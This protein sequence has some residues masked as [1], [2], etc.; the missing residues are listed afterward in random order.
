MT[1]RIGDIEG[2]RAFSVLIVVL[3]HANG[4]L[5][6]WADNPYIN[7]FFSYFGGWVGVDLFFAISGFVIAKNLL[8]ALSSADSRQG[9][10]SVCIDF[11]VKRAY[12][13]L[14]SA[15]LWLVLSMLCVV[16]LNESGVWGSFRA[17][18]QSTLAALL[19]IM[20]VHAAE[21]FGQGKVANFIYWSL[22]LEEQFYLILPLAFFAL[23]SYFGYAV[24]ALFVFSLLN[25]ADSLFEMMFR[26]HAILGGVLLA[27]VYRSDLYRLF[28][29]K[30]L[31]ESR[32]AKY[33]VLLFLCLLLVS[34]GA[35]SLHVTQW[36]VSLIAIIA[37]LLVYI[38]SH[39][40]DY[41]LP[42]TPWLKGLII[43]CGAR[44]YSIYLTHIPSFFL[45]REIFLRLNQWGYDFQ[46][47]ERSLMVVSAIVL[48][49]GFS[50]LNYRL[51]ETPL[52]RR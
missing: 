30:F 28:E 45:T 42:K 25:P 5:I 23:R 40:K 3:H 50:E 21:T 10:F 2:L 4:N 39:N 38:A 29:P 26:V 52:R 17:N 20:N 46:E 48:V 35:K 18:W 27:L 31:G 51:V 19:N 7:T 6:T 32:L 41:I 37:I 33:S 16:F 24:L 11:W 15:W 14:P 22:S 36:R 44:S 13:L 34:L 9:F 8:P 12:R 47:M 1:G 49:I 43:W